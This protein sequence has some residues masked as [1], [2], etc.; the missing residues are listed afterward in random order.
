M[1]V[2]YRL[3]HSDHPANEGA[4]ALLYGGRWNQR[5][6][7]AIYTASSRSLAVLEVLV[8]YAVLPKGFV[9][10]PV[11]IPRR[12]RVRNIQQSLLVEGWRTVEALTQI[13]GSVALRD[14]AVLCAPSTIIPEENNYIL[15]PLHPDFRHIEFQPP[16]QFQFDPR[17]K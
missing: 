9:I 13:M 10:T 14:T 12:V 4:G 2:C 6:T 16:E 5:G 7:E 1:I 3:H 8:Y 11:R 15:N 17:L